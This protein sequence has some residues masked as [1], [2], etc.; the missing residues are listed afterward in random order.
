MEDYKMKKY[1]K[2]AS[3][4][5]YISPELENKIKFMCKDLVRFTQNIISQY[6]YDE[7]EDIDD[8][9]EL[10]LSKFDNEFHNA[11]N[12]QRLGE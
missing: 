1:I 4:Y 8:I 9:F 11:V 3:P 2:A 6:Q 12:N 5:D 7:L 10:V